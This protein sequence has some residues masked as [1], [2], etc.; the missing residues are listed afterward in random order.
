MAERAMRMLAEPR[1]KAVVQ[2]LAQ[3]QS[4]TVA[5]LAARFQCSEMTIRRDLAVLREE[6]MIRRIHGGG[7]IVHG[8]DEPPFAVKRELA[9]AEKATIARQAVALVQPHMVVALSAGTTT[10]YIAQALPRIHPVT[11]VTNSTNVA[12]VLYA[13]GW[14]DIILTGGNFRTPSDALVGPFAE[15][16]IQKLNCDL[17]FLG[18]HAIDDDGWLCTPN[19]AE[20]A[21]NQALARQSARVV[22]VADHKKWGHRALARIIALSDVDV[23]ITDDGIDRKWVSRVTQLGR[24]MRIAATMP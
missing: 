8:A 23:V 1:R 19:I 3:H 20:A 7:E 11:F 12:Q 16:T 17:L 4:A 24:E 18:V 22:V 13:Q 2:W 6:G 9:T 15:T 5:E 10:W 21:V 14:P